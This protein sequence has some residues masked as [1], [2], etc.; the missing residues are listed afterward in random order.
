LTLGAFVLLDDYAYDG[1]RS[2]KIGM[3]NGQA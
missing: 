2:Q 3:T 1:Y